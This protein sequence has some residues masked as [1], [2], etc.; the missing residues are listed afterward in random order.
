MFHENVYS[1]L[2]LHSIFHSQGKGKEAK[3]NAVPY[4]VTQRQKAVRLDE[5][6]ENERSYAMKKPAKNTTADRARRW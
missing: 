3:L 1:A 6:T 2:L 5:R 4:I